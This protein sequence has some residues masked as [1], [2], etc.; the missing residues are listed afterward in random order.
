MSDDIVR[1]VVVIVDSCWSV[2]GED[3]VVV[4]TLREK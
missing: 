3:V 4:E 2:V 1:V